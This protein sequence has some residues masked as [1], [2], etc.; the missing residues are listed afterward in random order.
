MNDLLYE[1]ACMFNNLI[2]SEIVFV[3][4]RKGESLKVKLIFHETDFFHLAGLHKM[5]DIS[6]IKG[7]AKGVFEAILQNRLT[8]KDIENSTKIDSVNERLHIIKSL[9]DIFSQENNYFK[10][11]K[12]V[13]PYSQIKWKYLIS[14]SYNEIDE[15]QELFRSNS[16]K[17]DD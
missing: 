11:L 7:K 15:E 1:S 4:G 12:K 10:F 6:L 2:K 5:D 3:L 13:I 8:Y 9:I 16:Y 17:T 14:F